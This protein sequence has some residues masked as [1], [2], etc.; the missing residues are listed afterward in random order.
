VDLNIIVTTVTENQR[1]EGR[2]RCDGRVPGEV[3]NINS[4]QGPRDVGHDDVRFTDGERVTTAKIACTRQG[5]AVESDGLPGWLGDP[6]AF[7]S[8]YGEGR[9]G[10]GTRYDD[11]RVRAAD[12][13]PFAADPLTQ[14]LSN[15]NLR[16]GNGSH[17][18]GVVHS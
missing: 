18:D 2:R 7:P 14:R 17:R 8:L 13:G 3:M 16:V 6:D 11:V 1:C 15:A 5:S 12:G 4:Q 9:P 10:F